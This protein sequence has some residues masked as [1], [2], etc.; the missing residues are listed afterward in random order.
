MRMKTRKTRRDSRPTAP[1]IEPAMIGTLD[2]CVGAPVVSAD[3]D[4]VESGRAKPE[5]RDVLA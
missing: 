4:V 3:A 2:L 1:P 5:L